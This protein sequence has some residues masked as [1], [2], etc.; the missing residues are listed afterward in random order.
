MARIN[1]MQWRRLTGIKHN[2]TGLCFN[3]YLDLQD[4]IWVYE[5]IFDRMQGINNLFELKCKLP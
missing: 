5:V 2:Y 4:N 1:Q 3:L